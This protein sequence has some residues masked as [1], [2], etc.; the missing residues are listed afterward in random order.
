MMGAGVFGESGCIMSWPQLARTVLLW[1]KYCR[2]LHRMALGLYRTSCRQAA[3]MSK[4]TTKSKSSKMVAL[5]AS[6]PLSSLYLE[7]HPG[8]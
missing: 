8:G 7:P 1:V 3:A 5:C 6:S 2:D 4:L